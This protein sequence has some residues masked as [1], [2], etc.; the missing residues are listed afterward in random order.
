MVRSFKKLII[1]KK[2]HE[3]ILFHN[4]FIISITNLVIILNNIFILN[5]KNL[6]ILFGNR[7]IILYLLLLLIKK[8]FLDFFLYQKQLYKHRK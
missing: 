4:F 5:N 2:I 3:K 7:K 6:K 8:M 1:W